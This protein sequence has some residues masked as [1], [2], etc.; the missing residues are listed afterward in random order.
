MCSQ[1]GLYEAM[2]EVYKVLIPIHEANRD[3]KKLSQLHGK[4]QEAFSNIIRQV[5]SSYSVRQVSSSNSV[6][7]VSSS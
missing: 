4:L 2:N 7:Q 3:F 6:K 5:S 1:A